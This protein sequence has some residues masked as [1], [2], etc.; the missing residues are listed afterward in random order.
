MGLGGGVFLF[1]PTSVIEKLIE[2]IARLGNR[3]S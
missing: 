2:T 3:S 1:I